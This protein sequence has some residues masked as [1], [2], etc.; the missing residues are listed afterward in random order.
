MFVPATRSQVAPYHLDPDVPL[1]TLLGIV[2]TLTVGWP[3]HLIANAAGPAKHHG[4]VGQDH[5]VGCFDRQLW[6]RETHRAV[7]YL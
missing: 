3:A 1:V 7:V 4:K 6:S 5:P 2:T